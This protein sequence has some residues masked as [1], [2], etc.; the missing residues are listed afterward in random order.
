LQLLGDALRVPAF[1]NACDALELRVRKTEC[2]TDVAD[3]AAGAIR[4]ERGD[5]CCMFAPIAFG[6]GDDQLLPD[7]AWKVEVDVRNRIELAVQE[8]SERELRADRI[9]VR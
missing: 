4:R 9:D 7:V 6:D 3:R 2:L 8:T 1:R 5:Q